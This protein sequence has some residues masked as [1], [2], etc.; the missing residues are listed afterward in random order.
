MTASLEYHGLLMPG[1]MRDPANKA[2]QKAALPPSRGFSDFNK[3]GRSDYGLS[4]PLLSPSSGLSRGND[5]ERP[6]ARVNKRLMTSSV[7][8]KL[9]TGRVSKS[10]WR[11]FRVF[12]H[13]NHLLTPQ[14]TA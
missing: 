9:I 14:H 13:T 8:R 3:M 6:R 10:Y 4:G 2:L 1:L 7:S 5:R 12:I 11:F